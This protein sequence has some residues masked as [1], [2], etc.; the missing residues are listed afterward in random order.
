LQFTIENEHDNQLNYLDLTIKRRTTEF[1][2]EIYRKPTATDILIHQKSCHPIEHKM[3]GI[4]YLVN[5]LNTYPTSAQ[6]KEK[7]SHKIE[8]ITKANNYHQIKITDLAHNHP[9]YQLRH[10]EQNI[11]TNDSPKKIGHFYM[12][13]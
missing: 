5:R 12:C 1:L 4:N 7:E 11:T 10:P 2:F 9:Q 13:I 6:G 8:H 3:A